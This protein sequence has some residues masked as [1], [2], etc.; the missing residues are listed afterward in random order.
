MYCTGGIRC[1]KAGAFVK[2]ILGLPKVTRLKGG[3]VAYKNFIAKLHSSAEGTAQEGRSTSHSHAA[4]GVQRGDHPSP[5][6]AP[7][8]TPALPA[9]NEEKGASATYL[10][11]EPPAAEA[12]EADKTARSEST[13]ESLFIGSNY[14]FDHRMCQEITEDMLERCTVCGGPTRRVCNCSR[15]RCGIRV[16][17]CLSCF[18]SLGSYCSTVCAE[19]GSLEEDKRVHAQKQRRL[20]AIHT[21]TKFVQQRGFWAMRAQQLLAALQQNAAASTAEGK[22]DSSLYQRT[23]NLLRD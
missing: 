3:I 13:G 12:P 17:L 5:F 14:V 10:A 22:G 18:S 1:V 11:S 21:H 23:T 19:K 8:A 20:H 6:L 9:T 15:R 2:Q 16:A 7:V 4:A